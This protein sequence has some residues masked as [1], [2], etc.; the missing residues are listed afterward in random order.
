MKIALFGRAFRPEREPY[1]QRL[2]D[3]LSQ[4]DVKVIMFAPLFQ[5]LKASGIVFGDYP[6]FQR[7]EDVK[8]VDYAISIG[9]DG[10]LLETA[11]FIG[12]SQIPI[13]G[14]N[15]GRLGFLAN[16]PID[17]IEPA[18]Q[19]L[20]EGGYKLDSR[21]LIELN[22][23]KQLFGNLNFGL[24]EFSVLRRDT[25]SMITIHTYIDGQFLNSYWADGLIISTP[26]GS[27][28]YSLSCGGP[29]VMPKTNNFIISPVNPHNLNVR[30]MVVPDSCEISLTV[31][32][33][34]HSF[35]ASLDS[36]SVAVDANTQMTIKR[37]DFSVKLIEFEDNG[38]F[39]T[40]REK[41][42]WGM[43]LRGGYNQ[44]EKSISN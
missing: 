26:T 42:N 4:R 7:P 28:G 10:T 16:I 2:L 30:P 19:A 9:G 24:N 27:T 31:E 15:A 6:I 23:N 36:R 14:I 3:E 34:S 12:D 5:F 22:S 1:I 29:L 41:L 38:Y 25:S 35:L 43:D 20:F 8:D 13:M 44:G 21:N 39:Q 37:A 18:I 32:G 40:L 17:K 33:R 11:T